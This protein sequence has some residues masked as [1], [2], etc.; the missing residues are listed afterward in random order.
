[1]SRILERKLPESPPG[2]EEIQ[3]SVKEFWNREWLKKLPDAYRK[4][5]RD[6]AWLITEDEGEKKS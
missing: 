3:E 5:P 4:F 6:L 1:M 2:I